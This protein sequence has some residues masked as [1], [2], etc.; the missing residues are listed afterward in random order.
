MTQ[1][2][3]RLEAFHKPLWQDITIRIFKLPRI[4]RIIIVAVFA[5]SVTLIVSPLVDYIYLSAMYT[6]ET[7][8]LP[9][10][11]SAIAGLGMY[12][13]GWLLV[14]GTVGETPPT[15]RWVLLYVILGIIAVLLA[16]VLALN[17]VSTAIEPT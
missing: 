3:S 16:I 9:S 10:V 2:E 15:R 8:V 14:I 11:I 1:K 13:F 7:T 5:L 4:V 17:G 6:P 12:I